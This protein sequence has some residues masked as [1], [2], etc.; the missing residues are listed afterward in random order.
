[1]ADKSEKQFGDDGEGAD[2]GVG[3]ARQF[4]GGEDEQD[5]TEE[6]AKARKDAEAKSKNPPAQTGNAGVGGAEPRPTR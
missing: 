5:I 1:M 3:P 6:E 2:V 4:G